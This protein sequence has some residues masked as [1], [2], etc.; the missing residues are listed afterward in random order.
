MDDEPA[1]RSRDSDLSDLRQEVARILE[2]VPDPPLTTAERTIRIEAEVAALTT[3]IDRLEA[4]LFEDLLAGW[5]IAH[6]GSVPLV[7]TIDLFS[8]AARADAE[9]QVLSDELYS[10]IAPE[11]IARWHHVVGAAASRRRAEGLPIPDP[12]RWRN[13]TTTVSAHAESIVRR[14]WGTMRSTDFT[15]LAGAL[16]Q[17]RL[18]DGMPV[19]VTPLDPLADDLAAMV[20]DQLLAEGLPPA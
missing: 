13:R 10:R 11:S 15:L 3:K 18:Q 1:R 7:A 2:W 9:R 20:Q 6:G 17:V 5:I 8:R 14:T 4:R 19:P 12:Q 16:V